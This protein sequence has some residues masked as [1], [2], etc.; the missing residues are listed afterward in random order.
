MARDPVCGMQV[1][2]KMAA[3]T[4]V[5]QGQTYYFCAKGCQLAFDREPAKYLAG[6]GTVH[7][8]GGVVHGEARREEVMPGR[9]RGILVGARA[10]VGI[11]LLV[12]GIMGVR[13]LMSVG[14]VPPEMLG[15]QVGLTTVSL[16]LGLIMLVWSLAAGGVRA[17]S[18]G[19]S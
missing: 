10:L 3:A 8:G 14:K 6:T 17:S 2:E 18:K 1:E 12:L 11:A 15:R 19:R 9:W 16:V 13:E 7:G 4:S 5:Y